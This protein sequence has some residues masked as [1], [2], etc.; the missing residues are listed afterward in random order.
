L[1]SFDL[2]IKDGKVV[3]S[4]GLREA[5]V[6][7][8]D[9][10]IAAV[11]RRSPSDQASSVIDA[12]GMLVLPGLIDSHVHFREPGLTEKEDFESGSKGAAAGGVS[13]VFDMPT[14]IPIVSKA[15]VFKEKVERVGGK[16]L[17]DFALYG[18]ASTTNLQEL[19]GLKEVGAIAFKTY[20]VAPPRERIGEYEGSFVRDSG[21]LFA[22]MEAVSRTGIL[23]CVH[24]EDD[25]TV[26]YLTGKLISAGRRDPLAHYDSRPNFTEAIAVAYVVSIAETLGSRAHLLHTST[27]ESLNIIRMAKKRGT[28]VTCETCPHYLFFT[29][30]ALRRFGANAKF[31]PPPREAKDVRAMWQGVKDGSIDIVVSDHAPHTKIEKERGRADIWSAPPGTP[32][33]ETRLPF[34]LTFA[35]R[36]RLSP[37]D[38]VKVA[39]TS[40]ARI[41]GVSER[42]GD[43]K[44]GLDA[45]IAIVDPKREWRLKTEDLQTKGRETSIFE[46]MDFTG[47]VTHTLVRGVAA[48]E[49]EVGFGKPGLGMF[50]PGPGFKGR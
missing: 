33:V 39:S 10:R 22:V 37:V 26:A 1:L 50:L 41:Y 25:S 40:V 43:L 2:L 34:L 31:N 30:Q 3:A 24:A 7:V 47:K 9:G 27:E 28:K 5:D 29:K 48:Y 19:R 21:E 45:D 35:R 36:K 18:A 42:K 49:E 6:F 14:T 12:R 11:K 4:D 16:S 17:T 38:I 8:R 32:G 44:K 13:T 15:S 23:H 46:S 20:T